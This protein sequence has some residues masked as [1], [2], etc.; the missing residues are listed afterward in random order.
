M[1][2]NYQHILF[3][4]D[5]T[6]W[7]FDKNSKE[8]LEE[9]YFKKVE[10]QKLRENTLGNFDTFYKVYYQYNDKY[11]EL[12]RKGKVD[13]Q[14]VRNNR[15]FDTLKDFSIPDMD[16]AIFLADEYLKIS[17][18]KT[19]L[20]PGTIEL[21]NY[22]KDKYDMHIITNGFN[23]VQYI[24]LKHSKLENYFDK[25][26]TSEE[27]GVNKP[28]PQIFDFS[29]QKI[30]TKNQHC[31]MVGDSFTSDIMGARNAGIDQIFFKD[32]RYFPNEKIEEDATFK[33]SELKTIK[34]IL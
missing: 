27:A 16:L 1:I 28:D 15:F 32:K 34:L 4:L 31:I 14:T 9:L 24:K 29:L 18:Y 19:N 20:V 22:L 7:D 26:I 33:V 25:I 3:D 11:W 30:K 17:P 23:E 12:Y 6:L 13:K 5:H 8:A 21:L 10:T 2:K